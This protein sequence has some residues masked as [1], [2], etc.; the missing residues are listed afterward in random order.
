[1][2]VQ[3]NVTHNQEENLSIESEPEMKEMRKLTEKSFKTE[4]SFK[5]AILNVISMLGELKKNMNI[6][7]V[8]GCG[9]SFLLPCLSWCHQTRPQHAK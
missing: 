7:A 6:S 9:A 1:M 4:N 5:T 3:E 2:K 8:G